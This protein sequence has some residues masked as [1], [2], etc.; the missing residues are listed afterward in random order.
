MTNVI[1]ETVNSFCTLRNAYTTSNIFIVYSLASSGASIAALFMAGYI[2]EYCRCWLHDRCLL[3][4]KE[5]RL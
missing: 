1:L 2:Q 3:L 5:A 4:C